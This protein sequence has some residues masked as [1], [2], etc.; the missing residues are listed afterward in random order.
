MLEKW[1]HD[2]ST[3]H[4]AY[5]VHLVG[6]TDATGSEAINKRVA[7]NRIN[8]VSNFLTAHGVNQQNIRSSITLAPSGASGSNPLNR[9][10]DVKM[11]TL[12]P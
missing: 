3:F 10:V 7:Q 5:E 4:T 6:R 11:V 12:V 9:R 8:T 2:A 1:S